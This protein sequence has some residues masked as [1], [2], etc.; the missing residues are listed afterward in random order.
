MEKRS[1]RVL[2]RARNKAE[3]EKTYLFELTVGGCQDGWDRPRP[4]R[5]SH[6]EV[7]ISDDRKLLWQVTT[8]TD[9][10]TRSEEHR[11]TSRDLAQISNMPKSIDLT[12]LAVALA[13]LH[14][15]AAL[16]FAPRRSSLASTAYAY[17]T[18]ETP[19]ASHDRYTPNES[20]WSPAPTPKSVE[21]EEIDSLP[22]YAESFRPLVRGR[23]ITGR[24][25][26]GG[27]ESYAPVHG[28]TTFHRRLGASDGGVVGS[29]IGLGDWSYSTS[30]PA[31][32]VRTSAPQQR[33]G[34][35][36]TPPRQTHQFRSPLVG[37]RT[38][39]EPR[40][41]QTVTTGRERRASFGCFNSF[42][43]VYE[44][45]PMRWKSNPILEQ[46][47]SE[48]QSVAA[49]LSDLPSEVD[50]SQEFSSGVSSSLFVEQDVHQ[51]N[52]FENQRD[53][54]AL[55]V[56]DEFDIQPSYQDDQM[57]GE[58]DSMEVPLDT[59]ARQSLP[60]HLTLKPI[61]GKGLGVITNKPFWK[62]EFIGDYKGEI[63]T[64]SVK[65]RRYL[66]SLK[67]KLTDEDREWIQS[68]LDRGQSLTGCYLYGVDLPD[69]TDNYARFG[70]KQSGEEEEPKKRIFVDAEDEY[71][72]LW[73]RFI[74]HASPPHNN[75]N[76][77][78]VPESY[79]GKPRVWFMANRDIE[80]GEEICFDYG[81]D[82]WLEGDEVY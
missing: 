24:E 12:A 48:A 40:V 62:G 1:D 29:P 13:Q 78:S 39:H 6:L 11:T 76:P 74:N 31:S 63:M 79:D 64:E 30:G 36:R 7:P 58:L 2:W 70:K 32:A 82:Y 57:P 60:P 8:S 42:E 33:R 5:S 61:P 35:R 27:W 65:D 45:S 19:S 17:D 68:R 16:P 51:I 81:D 59:P 55:E 14:C 54:E 56:V 15:V 49:T 44:R 23:V 28:A 18:A 50:V 67:D 75:A 10:R 38:G 25:K 22:S 66:S 37:R 77:K 47:L 26:R 41:G 21:W 34:E 72:S 52:Q 69:G 9:T 71:H 20:N 73:T 80:V 53:S 46:G 3:G 4:A 43:P